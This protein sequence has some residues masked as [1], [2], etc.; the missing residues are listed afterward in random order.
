MILTHFSVT[1][2]T[3][4]WLWKHYDRYIGQTS[5]LTSD[6]LVLVN[7]YVKPPNDIKIT[8]YLT[9]LT[10]VNNTIINNHGLPL[11]ICVEYSNE[12]IKWNI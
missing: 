1:E 12:Y 7:I 2:H 4:I 8:D 11:P 10:G 9:P 6:L 3:P 5:W